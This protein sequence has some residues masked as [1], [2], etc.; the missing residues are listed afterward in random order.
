MATTVYLASSPDVAGVTGRY[1][2][3][4]RP[5]TSNKISYDAAVQARP[6][7]VSQQLVG[8]PATNHG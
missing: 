3:N 4:R 7:R 6:W 2:A 8:L 5:R 1:F